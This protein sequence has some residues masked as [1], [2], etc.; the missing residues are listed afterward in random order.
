MR[1]DSWA[2]I[3]WAKAQGATEYD[4]WGAPTD[5]ADPEDSMAGVWRFKEG[6]NAQFREQIGAWDF[7]SMGLGYRLYSE[8]LPR[9]RALIRREPATSG[10]TPGG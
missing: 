10:P 2:A 3:R 1:G 7:P 6:F 8:G 5:L 9:L 4:L